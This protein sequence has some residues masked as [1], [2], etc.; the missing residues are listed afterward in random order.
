MKPGPQLWHNQPWLPSAAPRF[1][2]G[3]A[4]SWIHLPYL[5]QSMQ[6]A[7]KENQYD[8]STYASECR[9]RS[10]AG[11][12]SARLKD[13]FHKMI[14]DVSLETIGGH[15]FN[16]SCKKNYNY[17]NSL[18]C[19]NYFLSRPQKQTCNHVIVGAPKNVPLM[20]MMKRLH[21]HQGRKYL[22]AFKL[23]TDLFFSWMQVRKTSW[24]HLKYES[25]S[26]RLHIS[27]LVAS[28]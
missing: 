11:G 8:V 16:A 22:F 28:V 17:I 13:R 25:C 21:F 7:L 15:S 9:R 27:E 6:S 2:S 20:M 3:R 18:G 24:R 26:M 19:S 12:K 10:I 4:T 23:F 1:P 5:R 14:C